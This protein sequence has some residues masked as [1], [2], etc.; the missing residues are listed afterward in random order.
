MSLF[1]MIKDAFSAGMV[2]GETKA[3]DAIQQHVGSLP[4]IVRAETTDHNVIDG[5]CVELE[6]VSDQSTRQD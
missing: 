2:A 1:R 5:E 6:R 4:T 3:R